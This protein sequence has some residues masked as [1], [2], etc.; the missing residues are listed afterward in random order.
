MRF[1]ARSAS[2]EVLADEK[3]YSLGGGFIAH[4]DDPEP[5]AQEGEPPYSF[6]SAELL[7]SLA[8]DNDLSIAE[9]VYRNETHWR[10]EDEVDRR[11]SALWD[12]M[13]ACIERGLVVDGVLPGKMSVVRRAPKLNR[14]LSER[15][16]LSAFDA[17][18]WV[19]AFAIAV[20]E[21]NAAGGRVVTSPTKGAAV[22]IPAVLMYYERFVPE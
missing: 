4:D 17:M 5:S 20:N 21:E 19:N 6:D 16:E 1:V 15:S 18:D 2:Q 8:G 7:L 3:Y 13:R 12:A 10:D 9:L 11:L 22:I 14:R